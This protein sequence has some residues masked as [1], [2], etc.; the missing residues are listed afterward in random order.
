[1]ETAIKFALVALSVVLM[2]GASIFVHELGHFWVALRRRMRVEAFAIGFGPKI[3]SRV[4][5]G[6]E[7]S[8][9]W[10]PAGGFVR[11]PQMFT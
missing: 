4:R 1:M 8:I 7:Y 10:I 5:N 11:L 9:R 2:F 3:W 6:I